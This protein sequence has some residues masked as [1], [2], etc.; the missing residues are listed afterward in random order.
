MAGLRAGIHAG[1]QQHYYGIK[2]LKVQG[3]QMIRRMTDFQRMMKFFI[4]R[5]GT[6]N[7]PGAGYA[8]KNGQISG[9]RA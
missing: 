8:G 3:E 4:I 9:P 6:M 2:A 7:M 1:K 5:F